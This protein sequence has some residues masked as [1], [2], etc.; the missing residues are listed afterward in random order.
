MLFF[1]GHGAAD[2]KRPG[3]FFFIT[4]D[5]DPEAL[6]ATSLNMTGL[7]FLKD[8]TCPRIALIADACHSG[9]LSE[10]KTRSGLSPMK[11]FV[12]DF[13]SSAGKVV[14]TSSRP[15]EYSLESRYRETGVFT[16]WFL[17]GLNGAADK[18]GRGMVTVNDAYAYAYQQTKIETNGAQHPQFQGSVQGTFPLA[19][20]A[21]LE[22][23]LP[24]MLELTT[25]PSGSEV[26]VG[27]ILKG[28]T[29]ND[30]SFCLK[31]LP[32]G[33]PIPVLIR[34]QGW[35]KHDVSPPVEFS[36][37]KA[38]VVVPPVSLGV[39]TA[40][41]EVATAPGDV[42]VK[43]DGQP[44]GKTNAKGKLTL[45]AVQVCVNH[46]I[47]LEKDGFNTEPMNLAI[48]VA[49]EGKKAEMAPV[50]LSKV[51]TER[52]VDRIQ[53]DYT[54]TKGKGLLRLR[55]KPIEGVTGVQRE[56]LE[57]TP[58]WDNWE[59]DSTR[60]RGHRGWAKDGATYGTMM[61]IKRKRDAEANESQG[62]EGTR[63]PLH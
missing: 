17:E 15:D 18:G 47:E 22:G 54:D 29:G 11:A 60:S 5:A 46:L 30:G 49:Y 6:D 9:G 53:K 24:T 8:L 44:V 35:V 10:W 55:D 13:V 59:L 3:Q 20:T 52:A 62:R 4:H 25:A 33:R 41:L 7:T 27:G 39:A 38:R 31:Y 34:K 16:H 43:I 14:I 48:P 23:R 21:N 45:D 36:Q 1:S 56:I 26:L 37:E 12:R 61:E 32:V 58:T 51:S 28:G 2:P 19:I 57:V 42:A 50:R 40:S 63:G